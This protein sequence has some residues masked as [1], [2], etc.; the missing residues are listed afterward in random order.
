MADQ[1]AHDPD[2]ARF[3]S[4]HF[5]CIIKSESDRAKVILSACYLEELL[6]QLLA[7]VL[8]P[9]TK[10]KDPLF[11]GAT[12]PLG[13]FSAKIEMAARMGLIPDDTQKSLHYV[14]KTRN[15]FAHDLVGCN[16]AD[17][18]ILDWNRELHQLNDHATSERRATFSDGPI[19]D[20]EKSVSW[21]I[22]WIK[23]LTQKIPSECP[24]C[25]KEMKYRTQLKS[26][27]PE[28]TTDRSNSE[29]TSAGDVL[30]PASEE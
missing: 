23:H 14:R 9:C 25:G 1:K 21:L 2:L 4:H 26:R 12:A 3:W 6:L 27:A 8:Q 16:F 10:D 18:Q 20:F 15:R 30:K 24:R 29:Q 11:H 28:E 19:G 7:I 17:P 5:D 13:T 22:Y